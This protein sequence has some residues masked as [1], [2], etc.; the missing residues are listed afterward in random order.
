MIP[1]N[2]SHSQAAPPAGHV[3]PWWLGYALISPVR[4]LLES[5]ERLLGPHVRPGMT[6][7]EPGCGMGYFTLPLARM[8]GPAGRVVCPDLQPKMLAALERRAT[9]AGVRDRVTTI[10]CTPGDLRLQ[11]WAG[12]A[13]LALAI[14][15]VHE[16]PDPAAFFRQIHAALRPGGTLLLVE[17]KGHVST[18]QFDRETTVA[19][20]AGFD[21]P[22]PLPG[23]R[24]LA[25]SLAKPGSGR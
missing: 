3:C 20:S 25:A 6:V 18:E 1:S 21:P 2:D 22:R 13:D 9:R 16:V 12:R 5:P 10:P 24:G 8:V 19:I 7:V 14:H 17:P 11:D 4:R 15:M 23:I